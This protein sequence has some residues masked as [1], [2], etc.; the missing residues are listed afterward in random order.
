MADDGGFALDEYVVPKYG[1][2][3]DQL[4]GTMP[5]SAKD[6][7]GL[8][9]GVKKHAEAV[10][11]PDFYFKETSP[12]GPF[13]KTCKGG[14]FSQLSRMGQS[15]LFKGGGPAVG[16][17]QTFCQLTSP[18]TKGGLM[19][20]TDRKCYV[21]GA[22]KHSV[23]LPAPGKYDPKYQEKTMTSPL[24]GKSAEKTEPRVPIKKPSVGPG[25]YNPSYEFTE[26]S[27]P[28]YSGSKGKQ[29]ANYLDTFVS[30]KAFVPPPG[31]V[32]I[33][34]S[35]VRDEK[36]SRMHSARLLQD[37]DVAPRNELPAAN[38]R[39]LSTQ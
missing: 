19:A 28:N 1:I 12:S 36:G 16:Q 20:K 26:K 34:T 3:A 4:G 31:H 13:A 30:Q 14:K 38:P 27:V 15:V 11:P 21:E 10:P 7:G 24:F 23:D 2:V 5:K 25:S 39:F 17:Y 32:G 33:P 35:K 37:R 6:A 9:S 29:A 22:I 8:F 18:R